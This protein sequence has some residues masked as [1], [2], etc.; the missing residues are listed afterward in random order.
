[1]IHPG[2]LRR[3]IGHELFNEPH[4]GLSA[5]MGRCAPGG[6]ALVIALDSYETDEIDDDTGQYVKI[7]MALVLIGWHLGWTPTNWLEGL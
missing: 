1:M 2:E 6:N 3:W 5:Y 4:V 7:D